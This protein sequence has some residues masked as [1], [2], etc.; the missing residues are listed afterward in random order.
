MNRFLDLTLKAEAT[1]GKR[2]NLDFTKIKMLYRGHHQ[3]SEK[4]TVRG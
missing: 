2:D 3:E 4:I 1:K